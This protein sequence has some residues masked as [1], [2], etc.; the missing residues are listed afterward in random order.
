MVLVWVVVVFIVKVL[1]YLMMFNVWNSVVWLVF[2][3][4][5]EGVM[6]VVLGF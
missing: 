6:C 3:L 4:I 5:V 1:F 2:M